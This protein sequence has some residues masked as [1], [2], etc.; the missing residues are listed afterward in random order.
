M[1]E[2]GRETGSER[3][4]KGFGAFSRLAGRYCERGEAGGV[5]G[6]FCGA[7]GNLAGQADCAW[8]ED[9][10]AVAVYVAVGN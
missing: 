3:K 5:A 9:W 6:V 1:V 8:G 10:A 2:W 7:G 4:Q